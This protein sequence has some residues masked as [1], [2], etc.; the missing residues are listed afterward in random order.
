MEGMEWVSTPWGAEG[1]N[2]DDVWVNE[3]LREGRGEIC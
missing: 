1:M 3:E 2:D